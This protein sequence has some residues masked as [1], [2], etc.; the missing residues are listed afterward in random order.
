LLLAT[1]CGHRTQPGESE[2]PERR[3]DDFDAVQPGKAGVIGAVESGSV[4]KTQDHAELTL[5]R[6]GKHL[7]V[8]TTLPLSQLVVNDDQVRDGVTVLAEGRIN[9]ARVLEANR[10]HVLVCGSAKVLN[11]PQCPPM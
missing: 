8:V 5:T 9:D 10:L 3:F 6:S 7:R 2:V 4:I 11:D 1:A